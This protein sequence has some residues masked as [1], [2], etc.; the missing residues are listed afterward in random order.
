MQPRHNN[1]KAKNKTKAKKQTVEKKNTAK[2]FWFDEMIIL[3]ISTF[4]FFFSDHKPLGGEYC[5]IWA[6]VCAAVKGMVF[7]QFTLG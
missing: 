5:H 2:I 1:N 4:A 3:G 7:K 6:T